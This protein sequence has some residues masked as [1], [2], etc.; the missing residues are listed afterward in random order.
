MPAAGRA[1]QGGAEAVGP[2][3][4]GGAGGSECFATAGW[5]AQGTGGAARSPAR[6][7]AGRQAGHGGARGWT[8]LSPPGRT[9]GTGPWAPGLRRPPG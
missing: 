3:G 4:A 5:R 7:V 8:R 2:G 6:D 1:G 9:T